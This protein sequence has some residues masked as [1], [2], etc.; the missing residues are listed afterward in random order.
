M[1][2]SSSS[3]SPDATEDPPQPREDP[4]NDGANILR[5]FT[6]WLDEGS[7]EIG[8]DSGMVAWAT[9]NGD[10]AR[11]RLSISKVLKGYNNASD[12][13]STS[14]EWENSGGRTEER[15]AMKGVVTLTRNALEWDYVRRGLGRIAL[16]HSVSRTCPPIAAER[17]RTLSTMD[18]DVM[19]AMGISGFGKQPRKRQL[20]AARFDKAKRE[21]VCP[22]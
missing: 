2:S 15:R 20:D 13:Q 5:R 17:R 16:L 7:D 18:A 8:S 1:I 11:C 3:S 21:E 14:A 22:S 19:A 6:S 9:G 10:E 12:A 4:S